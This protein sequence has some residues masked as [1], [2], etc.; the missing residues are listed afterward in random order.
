MSESQEKDSQYYQSMV[1]A[2]LDESGG[3]FKGLAQA[4]QFAYE[5]GYPTETTDDLLTDLDIHLQNAFDETDKGPDADIGYVIDELDLALST[6][7]YINVKI[8]QHGMDQLELPDWVNSGVY[9]TLGEYFDYFR[10]SLNVTRE[11]AEYWQESEL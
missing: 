2:Y 1:L 5:S 10:Q 9:D 8:E 4:I 7:S 3:D 11:Y 6:M